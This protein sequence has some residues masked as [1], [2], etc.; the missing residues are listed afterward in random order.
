MNE[1]VTHKELID[2]LDLLIQISLLDAIIVVII[3]D[4]IRFSISW[5]SDYLN[6][7]N[8][9]KETARRNSNKRS[10]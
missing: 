3:Y 4:L 1:Y 9:T 10:V 5:I 6:E 7:R 2:A 8:I